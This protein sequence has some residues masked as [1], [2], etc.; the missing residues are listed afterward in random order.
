MLILILY[1]ACVYNFFVMDIMRYKD[2]VETI[3]AQGQEVQL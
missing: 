2:A 3:F 1:F